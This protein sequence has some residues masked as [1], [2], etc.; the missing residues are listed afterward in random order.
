MTLEDRLSFL[1]G[2]K[3]SIFENGVWEIEVDPTSAVDH[4]Q[5]CDESSLCPEVGV[6][7]KRWRESEGTISA[8][9]VL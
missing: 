2:K 1:E 7:W 8:S 5:P 6:G 9:S 3:A 4:V